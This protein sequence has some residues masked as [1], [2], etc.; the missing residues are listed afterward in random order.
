[1]PIK[2][3][4]NETSATTQ[5]VLTGNTL[6]IRPISTKTIT[7]FPDH[8]SEWNTRGFVTPLEGYTETTSLPIS[9]SRST[10]IDKKVTFR[11][12]K[13][14]ELPH[15]IKKYTWKTGHAVVTPGQPK[16]NKPV[17]MA[18]LS[19]IP[20]GD[21]DLTTYMEEPHRMN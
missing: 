21:P 16:F 20:D 8:P 5:Y 11:V 7:A 15:L 17:D 2:S 6:K 4:A 18:V 3:A 13:T 14:T 1:M 19:L 12:T 10:I 9:H